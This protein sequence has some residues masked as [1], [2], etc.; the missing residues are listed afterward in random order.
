M[1]VDNSVV[2]LENIYRLR[3]KGVDPL[4][5]AV[6]GASQV[7]GAI[8]ASTLT[9]VCVF[10]PIVFVEGLTRQLFMDMALTLGYSLM[11]SLIV[12]LTLVPAMSATLLK[13]TQE[14]PHK[15]F[16][17]CVN[18]YRRLLSGALRYKA[19]VLIV[20]AVLLVVSTTLALM[21][22]FV[23]MPSMNSTQIT[24][25]VETEE[26]TT[27]AQ[28][29]AVT[30]EAAAIIAG[31]DGVDTVG[32]MLASDMMTG[33]TSA[34]TA[35]MYVIIDES[36]LKKSRAIAQQINDACAGLDAT[37]T[38]SG[39]GLDSMMGMLG[40][41]GVTMD[42]FAD[43]LETLK[44]A[45]NTVA[46]AIGDVE[47]LQNISN[48]ME[49]A[50]PELHFSVDKQKAAAK[51]LTVAQVFQEIAAALKTNTTATT[52]I[53]NGKTYDVMI[54]GGDAVTTEELKAYTFTVTGREGKE[55]EVKLSEIATVEERLSPSA[56][57]RLN[58]RRYL[59]VSAEV[60]EGHNV[61]L[62]TSEVQKIV[63]G[64]TLP[65][66]VTVEF[67]GENETIMEAMEQLVLMLLLGILLVYLVMVAQFQSL[68]SPLIV[69]FTIPL[70][71]TGG[72]LALLIT[73][74]E[75]SVISVIGF[76]MLT[77]IIVN[78]GIVLVDYVNQLRA[79]GMEKHEALLEAGV[80]R[81]RP[82]LMTSLTTIL[83]LVITAV[84]LGSGN[85]MMQPIAIVCIGGMVYAT[86]MTLFVVPVMYD[87]F[88]R[89]EMKV[90][91]DEDL[92]DVEE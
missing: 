21:R 83:G 70:A 16:D 64:I 71:F 73:G 86:L 34:T 84:G 41:T 17:K 89:K 90:I 28:T 1:L 35:T 14:K 32:A 15:F 77:G 20:S 55:Q 38:A 19:A 74:F 3:N 57:N 39:S 49:D 23:F 40:G 9:T 81:M 44:A 92:T 85:E 8:A 12:A 66:G 58:Q 53:Q 33:Q 47:G 13:N 82:I 54:V 59:T 67:T 63:G 78:N 61:T 56:I 75:V 88:N 72:F 80:T 52:L 36:H 30:D 45:A 65:E 6:S 31:I 46:E 25:S 76:V 68:K 37:V 69:M 50:D 48:G 51:G 26:G 4:R 60:A 62:L 24:V 79:E 22:G 91:R 43:D 42:V 11:A 87:L 7:A 18:V 27:L 2:V 29:K 10:L 5:A